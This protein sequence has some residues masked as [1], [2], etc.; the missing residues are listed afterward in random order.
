MARMT[1]PAMLIDTHCHVDGYPDP[2]A[3]A[4]EI[5][6][7]GITTVAVTNLPSHYELG[8]RFVQSHR[9]IHFALGLHPLFAKYHTSELERFGQLAESAEYIGEIGLDFSREGVATRGLQEESLEMVL[10]HVRGRPRFL[11]LH[12]R[13]AEEQVVAALRR[14][15]ISGAVLHWYRGSIRVLHAALD[16][17]HYFSVNTA[18][19]G[20]PRGMELVS[21]I[22]R[23]RLLTESDGPYVRVGKRPAGPKDVSLVLSALA[24]V[25]SLSEATA[26][27]IVCRNFRKITEALD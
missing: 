13:R 16:D 18:M 22:P 4:H 1:R 27:D 6:R 9:H 15:G 8:K 20:A 25:W 23:D 21:K 26:A 14:H 24:E 10:S 7:C 2:A 11:T 19:V 5:E 12:S 3:A 17:G